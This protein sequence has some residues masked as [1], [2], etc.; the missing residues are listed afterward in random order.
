MVGL[1]LAVGWLNAGCVERRFVVTSEPP[2]AKVLG[3][4]QDLGPTPADDAFVYYG[5]YHFTLI[6]EG[7]ETLQVD[8]SV[9]PPWYQY[10]AID[11]FSENIIPW[12]IRCSA[13]ALSTATYPN[14]EY[15]NRDRPCTGNTK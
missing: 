6:K 13:A 4:G 2:G 3:N 10:P 14:P 9:N 8:Q 12:K 1:A 15:Q 11:F 7:Y 5:N